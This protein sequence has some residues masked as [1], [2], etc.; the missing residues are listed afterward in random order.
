MQDGS[1]PQDS[2]TIEPHAQEWLEAVLDAQASA[3]RLLSATTIKS[4]A[5]ALVNYARTV[6]SP[7]LVPASA[8]ADRLVGAAL[9]LSDGQLRASDDGSTPAGE[10]VLLVEAVAAQTTGLASQRARLLALGANSVRVV[11][12]RVLMGR[13]AEVPALLDSVA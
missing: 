2:R 7:M 8:M 9:L 3:A 5:E 4:S 10:D 13:D 12:L 6:G 1:Q 11:A